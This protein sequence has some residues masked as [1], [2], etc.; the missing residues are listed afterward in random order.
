MTKGDS[1]SVH[2]GHFLIPENVW[3]QLKQQAKKE[4]RA[5]TSILLEALSSYLK[6]AS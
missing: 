5:M 6:K 2:Q 1:V 4:K 3:K